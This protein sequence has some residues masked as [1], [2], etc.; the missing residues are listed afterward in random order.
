[1]DRQKKLERQKETNLYIYI[2]IYIYME[3]NNRKPDSKKKI[4][5]RSNPEVMIFYD[6]KSTFRFYAVQATFF[7]ILKS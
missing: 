2:Y 3:V 4:E 7:T 1:M 6:G 5:K